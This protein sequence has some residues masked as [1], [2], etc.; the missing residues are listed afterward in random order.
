MPLRGRSWRVPDRPTNTW[1]SSCRARRSPKPVRRASTPARNPASS[2]R[3]GGSRIEMRQAS[4]TVRVFSNEALDLLAAAANAAR[5]ADGAPEIMPIEPWPDP[6][7]G[8]R[9]RCYRLAGVTS[10]DPSPL[11]MRRFRSTNLMVNIVEPWMK[12]RDP[13]MSSP[14]RH[15]DFEQMSLGLKGAFRHGVHECGPC[16]GPRSRCR[17]RERRSVEE[18]RH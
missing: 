10:P 11:K 12:R 7:G 16:L 4:R 2:F 1:P 8:F 5:H 18:M 3:R 17:A 6:I 14:R 15:D 9:L 13:A